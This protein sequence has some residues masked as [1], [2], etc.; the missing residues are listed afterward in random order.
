M[1]LWGGLQERL[2][3]PISELAFG[4][5]VTLVMAITGTL[6]D[7]ARHLSR[8][9]NLEAKLA[10]LQCHSLAARASSKP[11]AGRLSSPRPHISLGQLGYLH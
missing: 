1:T 8:W 10:W 4:S 2:S 11:A 9:A 3:S 5:S 7:T 6:D